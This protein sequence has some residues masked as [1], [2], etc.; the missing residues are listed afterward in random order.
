MV[1]WESD[2]T[3]FFIRDVNG[4]IL[5]ELPKTEA[6]WYLWDA[7]ISDRDSDKDEI[8]FQDADGYWLLD[9]KGNLDIDALV[10]FFIDKS[11]DEK[12][13]LRKYRIM[14]KRSFGPEPD[15]G[16]W[17]STTPNPGKL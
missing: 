2:W 3:R 15:K 10:K 14:I 7:D 16:P 13:L 4:H 17:F 8:L 5:Y 9:W 1:A 6:D 11:I 12:E